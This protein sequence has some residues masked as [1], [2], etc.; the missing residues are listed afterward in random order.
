M[1]NIQANGLIRSEA[2]WRQ[3]GYQVELI[4]TATRA[5]NASE[6]TAVAEEIYLAHR[7]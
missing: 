5:V 6:L 3:N 7:H 2:L 1:Y 4:L